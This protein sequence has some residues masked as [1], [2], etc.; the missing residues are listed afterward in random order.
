MLD[1]QFI[2][3]NPE[4][5]DQNLIRRGHAPRA[6]DILERDAR[7]R[8]IK[9][10][11]NGL[12]KERKDLAQ[13]YARDR[14]ISLQEQA[15]AL[16]TEIR[17]I[18]TR[19]QEEADKLHDMLITLP[20]ILM[21]GVPD[22]TDERGNVELRRWGE[23]PHF[24]CV[25]K[26][27]FELGEALGQLDFE[28]GVKLAGTRFSVLRRDLAR[29]HRALGQ[30]MIDLHV[31]EHGFE[32][33]DVPLLMQP[34]SMEATTH[35]PKFDNGFCTTDNRWLIPSAE[36]PLINLYRDTI[37]DPED[38]PIRMTALTPCFRSEAGAAGRDTRGMLRQHQFYKVE[39]VTIIHPDTWRSEFDH[40]AA[41]GERVL[42]QLNIPYR[43]VQLCAGDCA[44]KEAYAVDPEAW[45]PGQNNYREICTWACTSDYQSRRAQIRIR[46]G[47]NKIHPYVLYGSGTAVGRAFIAVLEN[48]QQPDGSILI[49]EVLRPY[50]RG[51]ERIG[52]A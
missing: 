16:K 47:Q 17:E 48:Y 50:M 26:T 27:H 44:D 39:M 15:A 4:T 37:L 31:D 43:L 14:N 24:D 34:V 38:L 13:Q 35:L 7:V 30:Y 28:L 8:D 42:Q 23:I 51:R 19:Q 12:K 46:E 6:R 40:I 20:N 45:M 9:T 25:P 18:E 1:I 33:I 10:R 22:G 21:T 49:P 36:V 41:C 3:N 29:L 32:E 2:R 52:S 11:I 5:F